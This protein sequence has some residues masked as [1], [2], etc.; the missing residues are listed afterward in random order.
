LPGINLF[1]PYLAVCV[2]V[3]ES[4]SREYERLGISQG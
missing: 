4:M 3:H 1:V 2:L